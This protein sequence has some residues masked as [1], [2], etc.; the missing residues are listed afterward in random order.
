MEGLYF[1]VAWD[2]C[3]HLQLPYNLEQQSQV[4]IVLLGVYQE[5]FMQA[6]LIE[7]ASATMASRKRPHNILRKTTLHA[8]SL[9]LTLYP[10]S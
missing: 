9:D 4:L 5:L 2:A 1:S 10:T 6:V 8:W 3:G 7:K